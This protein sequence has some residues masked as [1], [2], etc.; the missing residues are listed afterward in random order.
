[1]IREAQGGVK[2]GRLRKA[3]EVKDEKPKKE[4]RPDI[5]DADNDEGRN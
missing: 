5:D 4:S 2:K 1:L 3:G